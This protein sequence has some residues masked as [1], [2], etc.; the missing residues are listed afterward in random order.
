MKS[1]QKSF[2]HKSEGKNFPTLGV[3]LLLVF[4]LTQLISCTV[5]H[6][7]EADRDQA[8][9]EVS[10]GEVSLKGDQAHIEKLRKD[11]PLE[12]RRENDELKELLSLMGE[13]KEPPSRVRE[14]FN[15]ILRK[16]T[17]ANKREVGKARKIF[18]REEKRLKKDKLKFFKKEREEFK[19][20]KAKRE[21]TREFYADQDRRRREFFSDSREKRKDFETDMRQKSRDFS[22]YLRERRREFNEEYKNYSKKYRELKKKKRLEEKEKRRARSARSYQKP[23]AQPNNEEMKLLKEFDKMKSVPSEKLSSDDK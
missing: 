16:K 12:V 3:N 6:K 2:V 15:R 5:V 13:V 22:S 21:E 11:I 1:K 4:L 17:A 14:K 10:A 23:Q 19:S 9:K 18:S 20:K 7:R 8:E